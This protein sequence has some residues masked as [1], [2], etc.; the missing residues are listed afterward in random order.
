M[1]IIKSGYDNI[2]FLVYGYYY[3]KTKDFNFY[4][5]KLI[6]SA[7]KTLGKI[8]GDTWMDVSCFTPSKYNIYKR[9]RNDEWL[10]YNTL[11]NTMVRLDDTE[12]AKLLGRE[13]KVTKVLVTNFVKNGLWIPKKLNEKS[14]YLSMAD[15]YNKLNLARSHVGFNLTTT[16]RCNAKCPYC[17]EKGVRKVNFPKNKVTALLDFMESKVGNR[18][19]RQIVLNWFGGEP[20]INKPF[21][22]AVIEGLKSRNINYSSYIIT[23]GSLINESLVRNE[24]NDWNVKNVQITID[25][26]KETYERVKRY[27]PSQKFTFESLLDVIKLF[28][29]TEIDVH[30]R[31]NVSR[32]NRQEMLELAELLQSKFSADENITYYPAFLTGIGDDLSPEEKQA[33]VKELLL[34]I[35]NPRKM[36]MLGRITQVPLTRPCMVNDPNCY[37]VDVNGDVYSCE[38]RVGRKELSIGSLDHFDERVNRKRSKLN[39]PNYCK[40]CVFLPKCCGGCC[41]NDETNDERCMIIRYLL[42][43]YLDIIADM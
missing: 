3:H 6:N 1:N 4:D 42:S 9:T 10:V 2:L 24:F 18:E 25:G 35:K 26:L 41:A 11:Y 33:F 36:N 38:H 5:K 12:Y 17:Y 20:L 29:G 21:V 27:A 40:K 39:I 13:L 16:L 34:S 43:A 31:L 15:T 22:S 14:V 28:S 37:T 30:L 8:I 32:E 23:N 7:K 19:D